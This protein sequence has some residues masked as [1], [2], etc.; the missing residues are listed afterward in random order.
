[1]NKTHVHVVHTRICNKF[2]DSFSRM[3]SDFQIG[4]RSMNGNKKQ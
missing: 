4:Q 2:D 1:M 3:Y